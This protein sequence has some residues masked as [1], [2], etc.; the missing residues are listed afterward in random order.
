MVVDFYTAIYT[1]CRIMKIAFVWFENR[2][3]L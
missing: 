2:T 1:K 3:W